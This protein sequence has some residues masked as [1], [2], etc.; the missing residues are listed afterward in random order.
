MLCLVSAN[1]TTWSQQLG[2]VEYTRN[3][4]PCS[5]MGLLPFE[6]SLGFQAPLFPEQ[7][8]LE[9]AYLNSHRTPDKTGEVLQI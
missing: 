1:P 4:L 5:A 6:C 8:E 7:E 9:R 2:W 3:T